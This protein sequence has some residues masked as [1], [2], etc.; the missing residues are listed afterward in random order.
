VYPA[1][2]V[3]NALNKDVAS[4]LWVGGQGGMEASLVKRAG[5]PFQTIPAA[6]VH[7]VGLRTLPG[8]IWKLVRGILAS[9]HILANFNPDILLFTGGYIAVPMAIAGRHLPTLLVVP[10]IEPGLA[11]KLLARFAS[12]IALTNQE[13]IQ[14]F[15][16]NKPLTVT[17]Y[18]TRPELGVWTREEGLKKLN[19]QNDLPVLLIFGGSKGARSI[20]QVVLGSLPVLLNNTQIVHISGEL[21]WVEVDAARLTLAEPIANHYHPYPYLHEE[22]GA[23]LASA[24]LA[25]TRAGAST[26]GELPQFG[27]PA[28]IIP[29][30][31]AWHYQKVNADYLT[32]QGAA[33]MLENDRLKD[34]LLPFLLKLLSQPQKLETMRTVMRSLAH[35]QAAREIANL[36]RRLVGI[37]P[38]NSGEPSSW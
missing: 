36:A 38:K 17:G 14:F 22:M 10:D 34:D 8:N 9:R 35:P 33:V 18:P 7:G 24:D 12:H 6:G 30:P 11:L 15:P 31:H 29:Y 26:L 19:L 5:I 1:L 3:L 28:V 16:K 25:V 27:L 13:S 37:S 21:D 2:A 32:R 4:V 20:N 23:A